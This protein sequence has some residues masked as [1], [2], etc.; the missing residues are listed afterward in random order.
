VKHPREIAQKGQI[1]RRHVATR[2]HDV[3]RGLCL[4]EQAHDLAFGTPGLLR[5]SLG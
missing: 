5:H 2:R 3:A 4:N 1:F